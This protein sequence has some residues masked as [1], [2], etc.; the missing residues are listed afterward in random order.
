MKN[1]LLIIAYLLICV[2]F[3]LLTMGVSIYIA[4]KFFEIQGHVLDLIWF[5][6]LVAPTCFTTYL[7]E[8]YVMKL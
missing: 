7:F 5:A 2:L 4:I 6:S 1:M 8:K 3:S